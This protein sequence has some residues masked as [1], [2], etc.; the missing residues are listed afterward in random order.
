[1]PNIQRHF[2]QKRDIMS[3]FL[4]IPFDIF[5]IYS[6]FSPHTKK[7]VSILLVISTS[8]LFLAAGLPRLPYGI[9]KLSR[10][11]SLILFEGAGKGVQVGISDPL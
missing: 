6:S 5:Y 11:D 1:M 4:Q 7:D 8:F 2:Y 10:G 9:L 3:I